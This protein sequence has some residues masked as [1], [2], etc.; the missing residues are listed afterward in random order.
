M[1]N[2]TAINFRGDKPVALGPHPHKA[3]ASPEEV[4]IALDARELAVSSLG[5]TTRV[6]WATSTATAKAG[7]GGPPYRYEQSKLPVV[8][9]SSK[10]SSVYA[11]MH[12]I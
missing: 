7:C 9:I 12:F 11:N 3:D 8:C 1:S 4:L 5:V 2:A 10:W 6:K